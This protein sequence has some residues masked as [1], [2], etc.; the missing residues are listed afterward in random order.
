MAQQGRSEWDKNRD[1]KLSD[2][3]YLVQIAIVIV[4][5][6]FH[7]QILVHFHRITLIVSQCMLRDAIRTLY[8]FDRFDVR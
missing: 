3:L 5:S 4:Y 1:L 7:M 8:T 2:F 6:D